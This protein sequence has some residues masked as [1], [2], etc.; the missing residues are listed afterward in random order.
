MFA[1]ACT[2]VSSRLSVNPSNH[3]GRFRKPSSEALTLSLFYFLFWVFG[4]SRDQFPGASSSLRSDPG[5][6]G[7]LDDVLDESC[8]GDVE[9]EV[10]PELDDNPRTT[11][12]TNFFHFASNVLPLFSQ[13]WFFTA[14]PLMIDVSVFFTEFPSDRTAGLSSS[15]C[16][17]TKRSRS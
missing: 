10:V 6:G 14:G 11:I 1:G 15:N 4:E 13:P 17:V 16:T 3:S 5:L 12:D 2:S 7:V 8:D 9:D